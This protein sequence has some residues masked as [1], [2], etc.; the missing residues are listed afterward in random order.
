MLVCDYHIPAKT[1]KPSILGGTILPWTTT[2]SVAVA[3]ACVSISALISALNSG[4]PDPSSAGHDLLTLRISKSLLILTGISVFVTFLS[5]E[6]N[7]LKAS[8]TALPTSPV[9]SP[10]VL[11]MALPISPKKPRL[12][13]RLWY[14]EDEATGGRE[15]PKL[16]VP[17]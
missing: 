14:L 2:P 15:I 17:R 9:V 5:N 12:K 16:T 11:S 6:L 7:L 4:F 10:V 3:L 1:P 13:K 8:S